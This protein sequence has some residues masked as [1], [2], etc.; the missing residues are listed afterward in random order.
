MSEDYDCPACGG[1]MKLREGR[2][3][4][5]WGCRAYPSCVGTRRE[6]GTPNGAAKRVS[7]PRPA[8]PVALP[9]E[10]APELEAV[11]SP[12]PE[13]EEAPELGASVDVS[14]IPPRPAYLIL[15]EHQEAVVA[16]RAGSAVVAAAAGAG[17]TACMIER[18]AALLMDGVL[19]EHICTLAYNTSAARDLKTRLATRIGAEVATRTQTATFHGWAFQI[20]KRWEPRNPSYRTERIIGTDDGPSGYMIASAV[21]KRLGFPGEVEPYMKASEQIREALIDLEGADAVEKIIRLRVSGHSEP[22][23]ER[24]HLFSREYQAEKKVRN[25]IDFADMLYKV[26]LAI[27]HGTADKLSALY[28]H[29]QVDEGQDINVARLVIAQHLGKGA[30]SFVVVGDLRQSCYSFTGARPDLFKG[31]LDHGAQLLTLPVN[32]RSTSAIVAAGNAIADGRDWNLGGAC[33]PAPSAAAGEPIQCWHQAD[34]PS[35]ESSM[36]TAEILSRIEEG[37]P[38]ADEKGKASY[39]CLVRTNAQAASLE[40]GL[41]LRGLAVRVLGTSGGVWSTT[42]GREFRAYLAAAEGKPTDDLTKIANK[43]V[44]FLKTDV[45]KEVIGWVR[46][47]S[48][49]LPEALRSMARQKMQWKPNRHGAWQFADDLEVLAAA[50]WSERCTAVAQFLQMDLLQRAQQDAAS[51]VA[52]SVAKPDEDKE[53]MYQ[54]LAATATRLGSLDAIEAQIKTVKQDEDG[55]AVEISTFHRSKGNEWA[56]VFVCGVAEG[57]LPHKKSEDIEEERRLLYVACTRAKQ[58]CIVSPGSSE[59][60]EFF[61]E[62]QAKLGQAPS[63]P[64]FTPLLTESTPRAVAAIVEQAREAAPVDPLVERAMAISAGDLVTQLIELRRQLGDAMPGAEAAGAQEPRVT[65]EGVGSRFVSI[66]AEAME[67]MLLPFS[68][69]EAPRDVVKKANQRVYERVL[70]G[71]GK[72]YDLLVRIYSTIPVGATEVR[73]LGADSIKIAAIRWNMDGDLTPLHRKLPHACRTRGWRATLLNKILEVLD[74]IE[75]REGLKK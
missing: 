49:T 35:T 74:I 6:D 64:V 19:P 47:G 70:P 7:A 50:S 36:V 30:K 15:D 66:T 28:Q 60:S 23:A 41:T 4:A 67:A 22:I 33:S 34:S 5:F 43:P 1:L 16:L 10:E 11:D 37:L 55:P 72:G 9:P 29:V 52:G 14:M 31:L 62:L 57:L 24:L 56:V 12:P 69:R 38:L 17:K 68:F 39:A 63:L 59:P 48:I 61:T 51:E 32:R 71:R 13:P 3:G 65:D 2:F 40:A 21:T 20:L 25:C 18:I 46:R 54:A 27:Q 26:G 58:V 42:M 73:D 75:V 44:R 45:I 8:M 53:A